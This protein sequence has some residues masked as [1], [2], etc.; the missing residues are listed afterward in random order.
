M[1]Y[2][3]ASNTNYR[4]TVN[5]NLEIGIY[6]SGKKNYRQNVISNHTV[7]LAK[8]YKSS[9]YVE[10]FDKGGVRDING[11]FY[12]E[13][14][15]NNLAG[16]Q[17][18]TES[19]WETMAWRTFLLGFYDSYNPDCYRFIRLDNWSWT[20]NSCG[21]WTND[22]TNGTRDSSNWWDQMTTAQVMS[23]YRSGNMSLDIRITK[24]GDT[25]HVIYAVRHNG[26]E[27]RQYF[28]FTNMPA[29]LSML[30]GAEDANFTVST[31]NLDIKDNS[32]YS[33]VG[34][35]TGMGK[36]Y[37]LGNGWNDNRN[38]F[39]IPR[40]AGNFTV[41]VEYKMTT[42][43][44]GDSGTAA[45][46]QPTLYTPGD[47]YKRAVFRIDWC[48]ANNNQ[49]ISTLSEVDNGQ[50]SGF[51]YKCNGWD[52]TT[53]GFDADLTDHTWET[54]VRPY[55]LKIIESATVKVEFKRVGSNLSV[56]QWIDSDLNGQR[57]GVWHDQVGGCPTGIVG[58]RLAEQS[59][60]YTVTSYS[61][62]YN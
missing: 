40:L 49:F 18:Y 28:K 50:S 23:L 62:T 26:S 57:Y 55:F 19:V 9:D 31:L 30:Y 61:I 29:K 32:N 53:T 60:T 37:G 15:I 34:S 46:V 58:F 45:H 39:D 25:M 43:L 7:N 2:Q 52:G 8:V 56:R 20:Y 27:Y 17:S 51:M 35:T 13:V 12:M 21:T 4:V 33:Y 5:G 10:G 44:N 6:L 3:L 14:I 38:L 11:D 59:S 47:L 42:Q 24:V 36:T 54:S 16:S 41:R 1:I 22:T 48:F